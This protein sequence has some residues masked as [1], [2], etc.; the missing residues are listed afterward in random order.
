MKRSVI[1]GM[2]GLALAGC[3]QERTA[4]TKSGGGPGPVGAMADLDPIHQSINKGYTPRTSGGEALATAPGSATVPVPTTAVASSTSPAA[5]PQPAAGAPMPLP[6]EAST[7]PTATVPADYPQLSGHT[8]VSDPAAPAAG[9]AGTLANPVDPAVPPTTDVAGAV[10]TPSPAPATAPVAQ[11]GPDSPLA[12]TADGAAGALAGSSAAPVRAPEVTASASPVAGREPGAPTGAGS[13]GQPEEPLPVLPAEVV[14]ESPAAVPAVAAPHDRLEAGPAPT[15]IPPPIAPLND[16]GAP[17]PADVATPIGPQADQSAVAPAPAAAPVQ[18]PLPTPPAGPPPAVNSTGTGGA[19]AVAPLSPADPGAAPPSGT[20]A[21]PSPTP[22][23]AGPPVQALPAGQ[24]PVSTSDPLLGPEP[25]IAPKIDTPESIAASRAKA[26]AASATARRPGAA[27]TAP[28]APSGPVPAVSPAPLP[29]SSAPA[30]VPAAAP[31]AP[32]EGAVAPLPEPAPVAPPPQNEPPAAPAAGGPAPPPGTSSTSTAP[33]ATPGELSPQAVAEF[34][35]L[36]PAVPGSSPPA[37]EGQAETAVAASTRDTSVVQ[38]AAESTTSRPG[39]NPTNAPDPTALRSTVST[40]KPRGSGGVA[41]RVGN[42]VITNQEILMIWQDR[43]RKNPKAFSQLTPREKDMQIERILDDM[44]NKMVVVNEF[45]KKVGKKMDV[46][47]TFEQKAWRAQELPVLLRAFSAADEIELKR[48]VSE[49]GFS[50]EE[51]REAFRND[52]MFRAYLEQEVLSATRVDLPEM[53]AYYNA[54]LKEFEHPA[55]VTW[56]EIAIEV[57]NHPDRAAA[58][59]KADAV[60][61]K[62]RRG[63]D[64]ATVARAQSEGP[65]KDRGGLWEKTTVDS[66]IVPAVNAALDTLPQNQVSPVIEG[67]SSYHLVRVENRLAA[68]P[69]PFHEVHEQVRASV[70]YEKRNSAI[71]A[72]IKKLRNKTVVD[73]I[74]YKAKPKARRKA[75]A[76]TSAPP[77]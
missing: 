24:P 29:E 45:K 76:R 1:A 58:R 25:N 56:R 30:A 34:M 21:S 9:I 69:T 68:G 16:P 49:A 43:M 10:S 3:A 67:P 53:R 14:S 20:A 59:K 74:I 26:K 40:P 47:M 17:P 35:S 64:F 51:K 63:E 42:D 27:A 7:A 22:S 19:P 12:P 60:L 8:P 71:E 61:E 2:L 72:C 48:K 66:Y 55:Q 39:P 13:G 11:G 65:N 75:V 52:F 57:K 15:P 54:H 62:L 23:P 37:P 6:A 5:N 31:A 36:P 46:V 50:F 70:E 4:Q 33:A 73:I 28:K 32:G 18:E 44:I 38:V 41:A 77:R